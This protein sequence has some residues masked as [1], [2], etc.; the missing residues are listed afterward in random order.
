MFHFFGRRDEKAGEGW[1]ARAG[2]VTQLEVP[3][4]AVDRTLDSARAAGGSILSVVPCTRTLED[5]LLDEAERA[6][7]VDAKRLGVLA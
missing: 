6:R 3:P 5:V 1:T 2:A 7:P 4:D